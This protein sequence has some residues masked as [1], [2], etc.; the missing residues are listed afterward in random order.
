MKKTLFITLLTLSIIFTGSVYAQDSTST[1][2]TLSVEERLG[3]LLANLS[4]LQTT[5]KKDR[6]KRPVARKIKLI[7]KKIIKAVNAVPPENC[8]KVI[9]IAMNDFFGLVSDLGSGIACGPPILPPF[10]PGGDSDLPIDSLSS[11]CILPP[12]EQL[13][14]LQ[15]GGPFGGSFSDVYPIYNEARDLFHIDTNSSD[16]SDVCEG[17]VSE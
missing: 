1:E 6:R 8:M 15:I 17:N 13:G 7:T 2:E 10:L 3:D 14:R 5:L 4:S 16:I 9:R 11:D 12:D